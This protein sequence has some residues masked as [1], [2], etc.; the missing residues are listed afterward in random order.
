MEVALNQRRCPICEGPVVLCTDL[1]YVSRQHI[2]NDSRASISPSD[3]V[4]HAVVVVAR[5]AAKLPPR[6]TVRA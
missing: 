5:F 3:G 6:S 1:R 4:M 2:K